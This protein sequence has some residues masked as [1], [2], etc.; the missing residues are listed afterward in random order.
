MIT[1]DENW[2]GNTQFYTSRGSE[3]TPFIAEAVTVAGDA[4]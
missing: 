4:R 3:I 1:V 2:C